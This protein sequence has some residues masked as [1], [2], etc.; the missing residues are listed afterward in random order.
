MCVCVCESERD[1]ES[2]EDMKP[3]N[4]SIYMQNYIILI[5]IKSCNLRVSLEIDDVLGRIRRTEIDHP[6]LL[7]FNSRRL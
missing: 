7:S 4:L 1:R 5:H 6:V 2:L 3:H